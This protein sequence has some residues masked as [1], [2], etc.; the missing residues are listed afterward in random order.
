MIIKKS[1][2]K[3]Q[4]KSLHKNGH[5]QLIKRTSM[6]VFQEILN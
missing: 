1:E 2:R 4:K 6:S 5:N 3:Q